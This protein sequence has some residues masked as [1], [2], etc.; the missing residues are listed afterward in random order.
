MFTSSL[1]QGIYCAGTFYLSSGYMCFSSSLI[2][3]DLAI[4]F[5]QVKS[6][7]MDSSF[8]IV[9]KTEK[10]EVCLPV[11]I[12]HSLQHWFSFVNRDDAFFL[13]KQHWELAMD[14]HLQRAEF[15]IKTHDSQGRST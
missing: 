9:V 15:V 14:N 2:S 11:L 4:P 6:I 7:D 5:L 3:E 12:A 10:Q 8:S 13:I 1:W